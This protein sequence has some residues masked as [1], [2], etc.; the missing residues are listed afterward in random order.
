MACTD[1]NSYKEFV[2]NG[3]FFDAVW[4]PFGD[5]MGGIVFALLFFAPLGISL[6]I[7]SGSIIL[8]FVLFLILGSV[9]VVQ[10]P[11]LAA[12]LVGGVIL[13]AIALGGTLMIMKINSSP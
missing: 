2:V 4:C 3:Q 5:V 9:V 8:P 12:T 6:Y 10:L 11:G 1:F 7:F 13:L